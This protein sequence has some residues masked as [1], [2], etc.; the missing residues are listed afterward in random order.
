MNTQNAFDLLRSS[1][2]ARD[3]KIILRHIVGDIST[4]AGITILQSF[5]VWNAARKLRLKVPVAKITGVKEFYGLPF[6]TGRATLDPRP[7]SETIIE[8]LLRHYPRDAAPRILDCGTG[9]GCLIGAAC[10]QLPNARGVGIDISHSA[11][12]CAGRNMLRLG[13]FGRVAIKRRDFGQPLPESFDIIISNPPYIATG[14]PRVDAGARHDP[15]LA[16]Y[17]GADGLSAYRALARAIPAMLA[18][19]GKVFLEIGEGQAVDVEEIFRAEGFR[20]NEVVRDLG[21]IE[22]VLVLTKNQ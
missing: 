19:G 3:A 6:E 2:N 4:C 11:V 5:R 14:D 12:R 21:G 15:A 10:T 8:A 22:R 16:L 20:L 7:D 1:G 13:L 9:T 17:A 18:D